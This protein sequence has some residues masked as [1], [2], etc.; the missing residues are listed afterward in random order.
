MV[1]CNLAVLIIRFDY[2]EI[3]DIL[4]LGRQIDVVVRVLH[5]LARL[6]AK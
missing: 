2:L 6:L 4:R 3:Y 1:R 5:E